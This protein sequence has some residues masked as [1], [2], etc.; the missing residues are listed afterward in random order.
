VVVTAPATI[1][2]LAREAGLTGR[3]GAAFSTATKLAAAHASGAALI[4][5]ACDGE[6]GAAKDAWVVA[7]HL[8]ELVAGVRLVTPASVQ[9]AAHRGS[10]TEA[11]LRAAG[12][13]VL[14]VP[15]RYVSSEETSLISLAGGGSARPMTKRQPFVLGGRDGAGRRVRPT[16]VLNAE[17]LWRL[18]QLAQHGPQWFRAFGTPG[19]PGPR[20]VTVTGYVAR[21]VVVE[22]QA[23]VPLTELLDRAGGLH[24]GAE[25]VLVGGL[26]GAFLSA[27]EARTATWSAAGLGPH[28]ASLGAGLVEVVDPRAC[29]LDDVLGRLTYAGGESAGQCGPCMFGLPALADDWRAVVE[30]PGRAAYQQVLRRVALLPDRGAC[31]FPDGIARL[32]GSAL[33][34]HD[35]HLREHEAHGPCERSALRTR[36]AVRA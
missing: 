19:E 2:D 11:R 31:R 8:E 28:G 10:D 7:H 24:P 20:L 21:P 29:P 9:W 33:R 6:P 27:A 16:L 13:D 23:G 25:A 15:A 35:R 1:V 32:A 17:T 36:E 4:V 30:R 34:V 22:T 5:N 3:G 14:A 18:T 12:L 26:A